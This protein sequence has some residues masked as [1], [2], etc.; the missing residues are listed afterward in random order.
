MHARYTKLIIGATLIPHTIKSS[1]TPGL[2]RLNPSIA[3]EVA[4]SLGKEFPR[5]DD[6]T[7]I[8]INHKLLRIVA[9][10]SGRVFV[11]EE[12]S[13][14]D[15]YLD[16]AI[17]YTL[18]LMGA[19]RALDHMHPWKRPFLANRLPEI[20]KLDARLKQADKLLRPVVEARQ[21]LADNEKPDDMLQWLMDGQDKFKHYTS[22]ELAKVQ[23]AITFAAIHTTTL[24]ATNAFYNIAAYPQ[25][26]AELRDEIRAVLAEHDGV[27]SSSALQ[28]MKKLDSFLKETMRMHPPTAASFQRQ[29]NQTFT[30]SNGQAIPKGVVIE[31]PA[32]AQQ[33][34]SA[35]FPNADKFEPFRFAELR[36]K[37][38]QAGEAEAAAQ[39]QFVSVNTQHLTFGYGRHACPGRFFAANEIKMIVANTVLRYDIK[40]PDGVT[41]RYQN[42]MHGSSVSSGSSGNLFNGEI[43]IFCF[44]SSCRIREKRFSLSGLHEGM[45]PEFGLNGG[46]ISSSSGL[47]SRASLGLSGRALWERQSHIQAD[48]EHES[49]GSPRPRTMMRHIVSR[50]AAA[51]NLY[52]LRPRM[53]SLSRNA[54]PTPSWT[55]GWSR[56]PCG[57]PLKVTRWCLTPHTYLS[58]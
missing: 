21:R 26:T 18:E 20:K 25:H 48:N 38:R 5:C 52:F 15:E 14:S 19:R 46:D 1:L 3:D 23:L 56:T 28:A 7:P 17:N 13:R 34:D 42:L 24:T 47:V 9:V 33:Q 41:G 27:F 11:G 22:E 6:W 10:V 35:V 49:Q 43:L 53:C 30:L 54:P 8:N 57:L 16:A 40:M 2:V 29:V 44:L 4:D 58:C 32:L 51:C 55:L 37:A 45:G 31:A 36:D 50:E 12:L 39:N